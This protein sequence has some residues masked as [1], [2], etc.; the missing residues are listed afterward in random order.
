M[1]QNF[2]TG[3]NWVDNYIFFSIFH[4]YEN[5]FNWVFLDALFL[6]IGFVNGNLFDFEEFSENLWRYHQHIF[7][8]QM[9]PKLI[10]RVNGEI[11][12]PIDVQLEK[13][14]SRAEKRRMLTDIAGR[15]VENFMGSMGE[16]RLGASSRIVGYVSNTH[17]PVVFVMIKC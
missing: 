17:V 11:E 14:L 2:A 6:D 9:A 12:D 13:H 10:F 16:R 7:Y 1:L 8:L 15:L 4:W 5:K 3:E